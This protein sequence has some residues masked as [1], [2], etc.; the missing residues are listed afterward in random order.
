MSLHWGGVLT[1][2]LASDAALLPSEVAAYLNLRLGWSVVLAWL[3]VVIV[4][5]YGPVSKTP[6]WRRHGVALLAATSAGLPGSYGSAY[7]LGLVFQTPST[8]AV[9]LCGLLLWQQL[10][11]APV[12]PS[13]DAVG[14][15]GADRAILAWA[16]MALLLGW[17]LLLDSFALLPVQLYACGFSPI[18]SGLVL[19][20]L[21]L[22]WV[23]APSPAPSRIPRFGACLALVCLLVFVVWR[24]P[25]GNVWDAVLDPLLWLAL[26][27]HLLRA[28]WR[29]KRS[30][31]RRLTGA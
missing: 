4:V 12:H 20:F 28:A 2:W 17:A 23:V 21:L 30:A 16:G 26:Q 11:P 6:S 29:R 9:M 19:L 27:A 18:V 3:C 15:Q 22:P 7:W 5:R 14:K 13:G 24:L 1:Q 8:M 31:L 10:R 25:T